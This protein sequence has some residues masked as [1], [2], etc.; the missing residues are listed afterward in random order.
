MLGFPKEEKM[1]VGLINV[2]FNNIVVG[3][4]IV[5]VVSP[6][7]SP[8]KRLIEVAK[9]RGS[10]VDATCGRRTRSVIITDSN[11]VILSALQ[12]ET[13]S[14]RFQKKRAKAEKKIPQS[15]NRTNQ[16]R[17]KKGSKTND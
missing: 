11:H 12:A 14:E 9:E 3:Q 15:P 2:G 7:S 13:I 4:R 16:Y 17:L 1:R 5:A 10:L 6:D 8:V